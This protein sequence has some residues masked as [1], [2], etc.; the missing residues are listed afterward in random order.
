MSDTQLARLLVA[1]GSVICAGATGVFA[2]E[3]QP[4]AIMTG[5]FL[6]MLV[7]WSLALGVWS[8]R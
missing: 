8:E 3:G 7:L 4:V 5:T 1:A 6:A 2:A